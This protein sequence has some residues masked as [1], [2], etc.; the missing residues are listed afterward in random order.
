MLLIKIEEIKVSEGYFFIDS[1]LSTFV[2]T[3]YIEEPYKLNIGTNNKKNN[4]N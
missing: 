4:K 1:H 2:Q 3:N